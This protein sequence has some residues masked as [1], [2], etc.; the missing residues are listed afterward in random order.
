MSLCYLAILPIKAYLAFFLDQAENH[1]QADLT[2]CQQLIGKLIN[3]TCGTKLDIAFIVVQLS[4]YNLYPQ[5]E[6]FYIAQQV[7]RYLKE[8]IILSIINKNNSV[9]YWQKKYKLF[10][11][12]SYA[13]SHYAEDL[14]DKKS[15]RGYF[16]FLKRV[17]TTWSS[18]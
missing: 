17:V 7:L 14:K 2:R 4:Y 16:F 6:H 15:I 5:I 1:I 8:T 18:K 10:G 12:V 9:G 11:I 13:N 3:L